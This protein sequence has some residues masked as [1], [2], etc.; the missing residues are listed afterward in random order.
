MEEKLIALL[1]FCFH[2]HRPKLHLFDYTDKANSR[3]MPIAIRALKIALRLKLLNMGP[4]LQQTL[5]SVMDN[6]MHAKK[7]NSN[8]YLPL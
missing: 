4:G 2:M 6:E 1:R 5:H 3:A 8:D 7:A